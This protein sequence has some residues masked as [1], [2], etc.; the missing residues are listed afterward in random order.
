MYSTQ[1]STPFA[2]LQLSNKIQHY[3]I[4]IPN[5]LSGCSDIIQKEK[6]KKQ[7][8]LK[9]QH[10]PLFRFQQNKHHNSTI[11]ILNIFF[12][13]S[14]QYL[15]LSEK[16]NRE[17][18]L[19]KK[20]KKTIVTSKPVVTLRINRVGLGPTGE[21]VSRRIRPDQ[22]TLITTPFHSI[23]ISSFVLSHTEHPNPTTRI[24]QL[25]PY[26]NRRGFPAIPTIESQSELERAR[27]PRGRSHRQIDR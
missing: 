23:F 1:Q 25:R 27:G 6:K 7:Q 20:K 10:F 15:G 3:L 5:S 12:Y 18:K 16:P 22:W 4:Y 9:F 11:F 8:N 13:I 19:T 21:P 26:Q 17:S 14:F 24:P 2:T